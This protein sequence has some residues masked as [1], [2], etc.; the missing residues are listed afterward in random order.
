MSRRVGF[1]GVLGEGGHAVPAPLNRC[2]HQGRNLLDNVVEVEEWGRVLQAMGYPRAVLGF[3]EALY[4]DNNAV[5]KF[6][7]ASEL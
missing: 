4:L 5:V 7:R 6:A 2:Q 1:R 3:Y